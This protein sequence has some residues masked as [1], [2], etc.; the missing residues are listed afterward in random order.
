[1]PSRK[2]HN[3]LAE[4]LGNDTSF[5]GPA[6][7]SKSY[8]CNN[9]R[10]EYTTKPFPVRDIRKG[11]VSELTRKVCRQEADWHE[12][13][14]DFSEQKRYFCKALDGEGLFYGKKIEVLEG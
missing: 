2:V 8:Q 11:V 3:S 4:R 7:Q 13:N 10:C 12:E 5:F 6:E 14:G 1:M 9:R